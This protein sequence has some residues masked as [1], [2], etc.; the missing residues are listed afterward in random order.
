MASGLCPNHDDSM[1]EVGPA[2][3]QAPGGADP[4]MGQWHME[5]LA[6]Q[7]TAQ[8]PWVPSAQFPLCCTVISQDIA[9][10]R[11]CSNSLQSAHPY[12]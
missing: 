2:A 6:H 8:F 4:A 1:T 7:H 5:L 10:L 11:K 9:F 3:H 12:C